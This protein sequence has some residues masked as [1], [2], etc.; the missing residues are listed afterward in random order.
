MGSIFARLD[1]KCNL[2]STLRPH[3]SAHRIYSNDIYS[4][5]FDFLNKLVDGM[6][7]CS[8]RAAYTKNLYFPFVECHLDEPAED[9]CNRLWISKEATIKNMN[10]LEVVRIV[11]DKI[12][13]YRHFRISQS[14]FEPSNCEANTDCF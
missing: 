14:Q 12:I 13:L 4:H 11:H 9:K 1:V 2:Q 10:C 5:L 6:I 3:L 7:K 8:S